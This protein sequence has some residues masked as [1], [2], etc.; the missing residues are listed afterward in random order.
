MLYQD[1]HLDILILKVNIIIIIIINNIS[2]IINIDGGSNLEIWSRTKR[3]PGVID[4][5]STIFRRSVLLFNTWNNLPMEVD[6]NIPLGTETYNKNNP[7]N[8]FDIL[9]INKDWNK[10]NPITNEDEIKSIHLKIMML[11]NSKER[12]GRLSRRIDLRGPLHIKNSL[13]DNK[14]P[15]YYKVYEE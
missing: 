4:E 7:N 8:Q 5:E 13:L 14:I 6:T 10:I 9:E 11:G 2:N 15:S 12:R 1:Q 3:I